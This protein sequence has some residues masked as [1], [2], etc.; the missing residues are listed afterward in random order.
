MKTF[1]C[2]MEG[3]SLSSGQPLRHS[4]IASTPR[5]VMSGA[6]GVSSTRYGHL[7]RSH[8]VPLLMIRFVPF[9]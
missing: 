2:L 8:T 4:T 6:M 3:K 9:Q 1:M 7:E 5:P